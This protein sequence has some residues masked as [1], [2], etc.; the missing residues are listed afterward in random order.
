MEVG[1][2]YHYPKWSKYEVDKLPLHIYDTNRYGLYGCGATAL[3]LLT[4]MNPWDISNLNKDRH[5]SDAFMLKY[6]RHHKIK[7][8]KMTKCN[9]TNTK[10]ISYEIS[11]RHVILLSQLVKKG[12]GTWKVIYQGISYHNFHLA[13]F[14]TASL[15]NNPIDSAYVL[16]KAEWMR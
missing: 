5:Y 2:Y 8:I 1:N 13:T 12:E 10:D 9:L 3:S 15:L 4:G 6:L 7:C 16:F 14:S 11:D